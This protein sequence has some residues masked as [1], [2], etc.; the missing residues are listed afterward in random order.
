MAWA[1]TA[2][3]K[4]LK[5]VNVFSGIL[6]F[7]NAF[8]S[9]QLYSEMSR[10]Y[11]FNFRVSHFIAALWIVENVAAETQ[12]QST[13]KLHLHFS[14]RIRLMCGNNDHKDCNDSAVPFDLVI[15][16]VLKCLLITGDCRGKVA[17]RCVQFAAMLMAVGVMDK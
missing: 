6:L 1:T 5:C 8:S 4:A 14:Q 3:T 12:L 15:C 16:I 11:L 13:V 10:H 7:S 9:F 17:T 2:T